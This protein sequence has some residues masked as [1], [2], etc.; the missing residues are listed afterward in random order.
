MEEKT[1]VLTPEDGPLQQVAAPTGAKPRRRAFGQGLQHLGTQDLLAAED[2]EIE[3]IGE[4][5]SV[6]EVLPRG[7]VQLIH[8]CSF[9]F[10]LLHCLT[11][12]IIYLCFIYCNL[13]N[14]FLRIFHY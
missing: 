5:E 6:L 14:L 10:S 8:F 4:E 12:N 13:K 3:D 7:I 2:P 1:T 11:H 9:C